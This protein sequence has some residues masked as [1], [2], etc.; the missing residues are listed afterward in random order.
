MWNRLERARWKQGGQWEVSRNYPGE[1]ITPGM[2]VM[3]E[4][5]M[6]GFRCGVLAHIRVIQLSRAPRSYTEF[7]LRV[8]GLFCLRVGLLHVFQR[9]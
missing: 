6:A 7:S 4:E 9:M 2:K 5:T 3:A 8:T 1:I